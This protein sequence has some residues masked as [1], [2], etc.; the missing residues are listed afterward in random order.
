MR[1]LVATKVLRKMSYVIKEQSRI[2]HFGKGLDRR[3]GVS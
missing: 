3:D 2:A 1:L